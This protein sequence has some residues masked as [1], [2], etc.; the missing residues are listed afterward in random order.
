MKSSPVKQ[1]MEGA[2]HVVK[3]QED[4]HVWGKMQTNEHKALQHSRTRFSTFLTA[5]NTHKPF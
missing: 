5:S 3:L 1:L 4:I 2:H